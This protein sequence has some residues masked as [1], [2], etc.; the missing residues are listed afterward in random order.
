[1]ARLLPQNARA[2]TAII[3]IG[4]VV[5]ALVF[6]QLILP[7]RGD[8]RGTPAAILFQGL[9]LGLCYAVFTTGLVLIYRAVRIVSFAQGFL[10]SLC[11]LLL[12]GIVRYTSVPFPIAVVL[13]LLLSAAVGGLLGLVLLRFFNASRLY[14]TVITI[15]VVG[16]ILSLGARMVNAAPFFPDAAERSVEGALSPDELRALLPFAGLRFNVGSFPLEFGFAEIFAIE[17]AVVALLAV[18]L[19]LRYTRTGV[20][21]RAL[22]ENPERASLLGIGVGALS[23]LV[24]VIAGLLD[25]AA[26]LMVSTGATPSIG[27]GFEALVPILVAAVVARFTSL[28]VAW[29]AAVL[30]GITR[31]AWYFSVAGGSDI[32]FLILFGVIGVSLLLQ[33]RRGGRSESA[34]VSWAGSTE[35]RP[36]PKELAGITSLRLA[37][38]GLYAAGLLLVV[39]LP[40]VLSLNRTI[41]LGIVF[42]NA[43]AVLSLVVLTGWAGQVSLGQYALVAVGA[44]VGGSLTSRVGLPFWIAVPLA[45]AITAGVSVI[46]G[47]PALRIKGLF[48]LVSTFAFALAVRAVLF[49]DRYFGWLLPA[50]VDRPT[51]FFFDFEDERSMYFLCVTAFVLSAIVVRNLRR[52]RTGRLL[53]ALRENE[54]NVA[55][56]GVSVVRSKLLALAVAGALAG[57]AGAVLAHHQRGITPDAFGAQANIDVFTQA[58]IGGVSSVGGAVLGSAYF[59]LTNQFLGGNVVLLAFVTGL[60]PLLIVLLAPGG[61]I[62]LVNAARDSVLRII[63]QRRRIVVPSLFAD[64]DADALERQLIPLAEPDQLSGLAAMPIDERFALESELYAGRGERIIDRLGPARP[65]RETAAIGAAARAAIEF[66]QEHQAEPDGELEPAALG[67]GAEER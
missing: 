51:L 66:E 11:G 34:E 23:I 40:F 43:I 27:S 39:I 56:F 4:V 13:G 45:S 10:G 67:A 6:T 21:M 9:V 5:A 30:I 46:V 58:V 31:E 64:Y 37:R 63:A 49:D 55:S 35:P 17:V 2:R 3:S 33:R 50:G 1:M 59:T 8:G 7:G 14:L 28:P 12:V 15:V 36:I 18:G 47:L 57:F 42:I 38:Y 53:I 54:N 61:L 41:I 26:W 22:A 29:S 25:G 24:W 48:L 60:G 44:V 62:S 52:S 32:F 19:F 65:D 20:A 16:V